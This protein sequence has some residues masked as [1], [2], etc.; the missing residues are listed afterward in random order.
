M[1]SK[2]E[3]IKISLP[4]NSP[5]RNK[6]RW[7]ASFARSG[8][9]WVRAFLANLLMPKDKPLTLRE[10]LEVPFYT[11]TDMPDSDPK[12]ELIGKAHHVYSEERHG[13]RPAIYIVRDPVDI[14]PSFADFFGVSIDYMVE[15]VSYAW[16]QHVASWWPHT[17]LTLKYEDMPNNFH[18]LAKTLYIPDDKKLCLSAIKYSNFALLKEDEKKNG[19]GEFS[20]KGNAFFR[21]GTSGQGREV[22]TNTQVAKVVDGAGKWYTKLGYG[23]T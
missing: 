10:I 8:N 6:M 20:G 22:M 16:P 14:V 3:T 9:T 2:T 21:R 18:T 12:K 7:L 13:K 5:P 19:F 15:K 17:K 4:V 23:N 1:N 11:N